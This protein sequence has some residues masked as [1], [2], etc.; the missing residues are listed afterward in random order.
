MLGS[1]GNLFYVIHRINTE[2]REMD[3]TSDWA[4]TGNNTSVARQRKLDIVYPSHKLFTKK[5]D[6]LFIFD[7]SKCC[8]LVVL[9][10]LLANER[11]TRQEIQHK[12]AMYKG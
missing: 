10:K 12:V 11:N 2:P 9:N 4:M 1:E 8:L 6:I 5:S 7:R 3:Y